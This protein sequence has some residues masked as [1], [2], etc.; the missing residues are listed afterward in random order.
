MIPL[1][2]A[3]ETARGTKYQFPLQVPGIAIIALI[4]IAQIVSMALADS[5]AA[6]E[7][8]WWMRGFGFV[9]A[10]LLA[11]MAFRFAQAGLVF[12]DEAVEIVQ[13][14]ETKRVRYPEVEEFELGRQFVRARLTDG[15]VISIFGLSYRS[16]LFSRRRTAEI[17]LA[18]LNDLLAR[19]KARTTPRH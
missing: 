17:K 12:A 6:G 15:S 11:W 10:G 4:G 18:E 1:W 5:W 19:R 2:T 14:W 13:G 7:P 9:I 3:R 16:L 8:T